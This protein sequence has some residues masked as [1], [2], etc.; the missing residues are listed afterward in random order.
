MSAPSKAH[1]DQ[2]TNIAA[3]RWRCAR[4]RA[5]AAEH[6][7]LEIAGPPPR[8]LV[9]LSDVAHVQRLHL[10][11]AKLLCAAVEEAPDRIAALTLM[12][13]VLTDLSDGQPLSKR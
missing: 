4:Q 1:P 8:R 13:Q 7:L 2:A 6:H 5:L 9:P 10:E 11:A 12:S 3:Q